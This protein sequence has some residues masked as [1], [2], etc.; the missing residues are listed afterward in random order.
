M[1]FRQGDES[2]SGDAKRRPTVWLDL[3]QAELDAA[4]D[5]SAYA[6]NMQEVR[7]RYSTAS[8]KN[9]A[10]LG[11]PHRAA[12]GKSEIEQLDWFSCGRTMAPVHVFIHGGAWRGGSSSQFHF[13][14][15]TFVNAGAHFVVPDFTNALETK[16]DLLPLF[17]QVRQAIV[18]VARNA[19]QFGG[20][21]DRI[22]VS[23]H[24]S[25]A[26]LLACAALT[27]WRA[28]FGL[29]AD[30]IKSALYCGG[31][32]DLKPVLLSARSN[33]LNVSSAAEQALSPMRNLRK[34]EMPVFVACGSLETPEF[35]RQSFEFAN[36]MKHLGMDVTVNCEAQANH[37]EMLE[38]L[39][40]RDGMLASWVLNQMG[41]PN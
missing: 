38:M 18:W 20:D 14:A 17:E 24:S 27:D 26:H 2:E 3:T 40:N 35:R 8:E 36:A 4:Y 10:A 32:Y 41:L 39:E 15:E 22:H 37:F 21:P 28:D 12:Y 23:G 9:R 31:I 19:K 11:E 34:L 16:G 33:Y 5:Q 1:T 29:P 25:G 13:P 7:Q 6:P 30:V